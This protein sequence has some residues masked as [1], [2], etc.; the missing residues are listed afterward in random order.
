MGISERLPVQ[1]FVPAVEGLS[2]QLRGMLA[3]VTN[4]DV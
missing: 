2:F 1:L 3:N 4:F